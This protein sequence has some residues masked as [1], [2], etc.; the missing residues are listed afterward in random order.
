MRSNRSNIDLKK[1]AQKSQTADAQDRVKW[2]S[3]IKT[4]SPKS[5]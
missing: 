2:K 3:K 1:D 5:M 4:V